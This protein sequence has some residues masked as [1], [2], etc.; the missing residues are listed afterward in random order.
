M[1]K[2]LR[3]CVKNGHLAK[4]KIGGKIR[5]VWLCWT[6]LKGSGQEI[7][8]HIHP[9][10]KVKEFTIYSERKFYDVSLG[11]L[12]ARGSEPKPVYKAPWYEWS[13]LH[14]KDLLRARRDGDPNAP[15]VRLFEDKEPSSN[16]WSLTN[17]L[18]SEFRE[19]NHEGGKKKAIWRPTSRNRPNHDW[20]LCGMLMAFMAIAGIVGGPETEENA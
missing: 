17:Q 14:A 13:N 1:T 7:F 9:K 3:E 15:K 10:T 8:V 20:D 11:G 6:G 4:I 18:H 2:V 12:G 5:T 19:E 16:L